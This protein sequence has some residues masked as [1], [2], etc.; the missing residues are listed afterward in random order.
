MNAK[1]AQQRYFWKEC[2]TATDARQGALNAR[3][4]E[5]MRQANFVQ[6]A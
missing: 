6:Y 5:S 1:H 2:N 4:C 3:T